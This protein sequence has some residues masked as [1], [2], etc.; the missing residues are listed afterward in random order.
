MQRLFAG[1][2]DKKGEGN[3]QKPGSEEDER[4]IS[5][6][7]IAVIKDRPSRS[8]YGTD[9]STDAV[10]ITAGFP[11]KVTCSE[12]QSNKITG[13]VCV[14]SFPVWVAAGMVTVRAVLTP[15]L[16]IVNVV[17]DPAA[18]VA[19]NLTTRFLIVPVLVMGHCAVTSVAV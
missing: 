9:M 1:R 14:E 10:P 5:L 6:Y 2:S 8:Y 13:T 11:V 15:F 12:I 4:E 19:L 17:L 18:E 7:T 16:R 3:I